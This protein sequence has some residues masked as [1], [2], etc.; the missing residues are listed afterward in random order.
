MA[1]DD[2]LFEEST[3]NIE[4]S[5][6]LL[7]SSGFEIDIPT[8][9]SADSAPTKVELD[10]EEL[11]EDLEVPAVEPPEEL[12]EEIEEAEEEEIEGEEPE[13][14]SSRLKLVLI[15]AS[16]G[17]GVILLILAAVLLINPEKTETPVNKTLALGPTPM[18]NLKPF[19]VNFSRP[20]TDVVLKLEMALVFSSKE[21][22]AEFLA[23]QTAV[24]DL[25]YRFLQGRTPRE[26][27]N[28]EIVGNIQNEITSL[29]NSS[30]KRGRVVK[31][32]FMELLLI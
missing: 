21:A 2:E 15:G 23:R 11:P 13:Q 29:V 16:A 27:Y 24:R 26:L 6:E 22:E 18:V 30:L 20:D 19:V 12:E 31:T 32:Y 7:K 28:K 3:R 17:L 9:G 5:D 14:T 8:N 4:G 10:I 1:E 25:I